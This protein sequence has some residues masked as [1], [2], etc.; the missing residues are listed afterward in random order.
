MRSTGYSTTLKGGKV[1]LNIIF[2]LFVR[3]ARLFNMN[4]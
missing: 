2:G 4:R 1:E 3:V